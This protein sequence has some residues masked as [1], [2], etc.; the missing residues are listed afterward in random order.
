MIVRLVMLAALLGCTATMAA[1]LRT[2]TLSV[3]QMD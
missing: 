1:D 2:A 3:S